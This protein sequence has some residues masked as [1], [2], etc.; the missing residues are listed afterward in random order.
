[1]TTTAP[2]ATFFVIISMLVNMSRMGIALTNVLSV[3]PKTQ[4]NGQF[5]AFTLLLHEN[6]LPLTMSPPLPELS[7]KEVVPVRPYE[8]PSTVSLPSQPLSFVCEASLDPDRWQEGGFDW[9]VFE[10]DRA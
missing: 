6:T 2:T 7:L 10:V 5:P 4:L 9:V 8:E 1:M 3:L